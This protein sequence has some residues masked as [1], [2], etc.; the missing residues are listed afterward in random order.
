M[1]WKPRQVIL[2]TPSLR[3]RHGDRDR[4]GKGGTVANAMIVTGDHVG[5]RIDALC[6]VGIKGVLHGGR[7]RSDRRMPGRTLR[8]LRRRDHQVHGMLWCVP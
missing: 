6:H 2:P 5:T 8:F 3:S 1:E 7:H 4:T